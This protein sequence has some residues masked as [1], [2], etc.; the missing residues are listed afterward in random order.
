MTNPTPDD[1]RE[2]AIWLTSY[3]SSRDKALIDLISEK[4]PDLSKT[5]V[6][7]AVGFLRGRQRARGER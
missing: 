5:T 1:W 2:L 4:Y 6:H 3:V 7:A